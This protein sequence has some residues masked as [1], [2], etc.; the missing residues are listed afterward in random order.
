MEPSS[1]DT[2]LLVCASCGRETDEPG[3][4]REHWGFWADGLGQWV[5]YCPSCG[6][7]AIRGRSTGRGD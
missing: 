3:A 5:L 1:A 4:S 6:P 2:A 7:A